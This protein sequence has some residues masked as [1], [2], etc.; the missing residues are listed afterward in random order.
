MMR[1]GIV[2]TPPIN[3]NILEGIT[4]RTI[5]HL[6]REDLGL[7]VVERNIDR[8]EVYLADEAFFC[9]TG[10]QIVAIASIDHRPVGTGHMGPVVSKLRDLYF[11]V[12]S[13]RVEK[14]RHWTM[15]VYET[16]ATP[17]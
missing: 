5:M 16:V 10:V 13:G 2:Y 9:G 8:S 15:P 4:R 11:K 12:V 17:P 14:Y 6:L 7:E 1:N 3:A